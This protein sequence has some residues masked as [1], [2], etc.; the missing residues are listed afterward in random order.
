MRA[1]LVD[2]TEPVLRVAERDQA[3]GEQL[4]AHGRAIGLGQL[5]VEQCRLPEATKQI[6][7]RRAGAGLRQ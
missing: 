2:E 7:H 5:V 1:E 6:A 4:H 3:L